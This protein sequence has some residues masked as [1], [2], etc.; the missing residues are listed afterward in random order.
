MS[1]GKHSSGF[2]REYLEMSSRRW[3]IGVEISRAMERV[4]ELLKEREQLARVMGRE[5]G[6]SDKGNA[7]SRRKSILEDAE[8]LHRRTTG[9]QE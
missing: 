2:S 6:F 7:R 5:D 3:D 1:E 8:R 9:L 4:I